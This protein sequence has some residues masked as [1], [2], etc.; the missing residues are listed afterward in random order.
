VAE[1]Y[2]LRPTEIVPVKA[3]DGTTLYARLIR[4]ANFN[5]QV[6]YPVIVQ[7][8]GGPHAQAVRDSWAGLSWDQVLAHKGF[9]VWQLDNRGTSGRGHLFEAK[10]H[11]RLGETELKDQLA[12][13]RHLVSLGFADPQRI[14]INGWSYGGFMT[15]YAMLNAPETFRAGIAGAPVTNWVNYDTIYTERY[16]GLPQENAEGYKA[17]SPVTHAAKLQGKLLLVHNIE[18]DNVLFQNSLQMMRAL[19]AAGKNFGSLIY[20]QKSHGVMGPAAGQ[21]R[22]AMTDFFVDALLARQ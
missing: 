14:G 4:P 8:Y 19:Q 6:K 16:L 11:R 1:E 22:A 13:V 12:G 15:L 9:I 3:D 2:D 21:M 20:P 5:P 18:D 7:V 10:L 17:S